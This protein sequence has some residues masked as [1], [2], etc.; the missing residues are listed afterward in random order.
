M[1][2]GSRFAYRQVVASLSLA[3]VV[4][5]ELL[6]LGFLQNLLSGVGLFVFAAVV[7]VPFP[8]WSGSLFNRSGVIPASRISVPKAYTVAASIIASA[9][10][11]FA[12][13]TLPI[14]ESN[15]VVYLDWHHESQGFSGIQPISFLTSASVIDSAPKGSYVGKL[16]DKGLKGGGRFCQSLEG[17]NVGYVVWEKNVN[18][19]IVSSESDYL[20]VNS[21]QIHGLL[22]HSACLRPVLSSH[23][24]ILYKNVPWIPNLVSYSPWANGRDPLHAHYI[25]CGGDQVSVGATPEGY[26]YLVLNQPNDGGWSLDGLDLPNSKDRWCSMWPGLQSTSL[27]L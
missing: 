16:I 11:G 19:R 25:A 26:N 2:T 9:R 23:N 7:I 6:R 14:A 5:A 18:L 10:P 13:L 20:G 27:S 3:A 12:V 15:N 17:L 4:V 8:L 22:K 24:L 1:W 21:I